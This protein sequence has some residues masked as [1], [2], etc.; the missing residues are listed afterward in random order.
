VRNGTDGG[1]G[2]KPGDQWAISLCSAH[3][4][5]QHQTGEVSFAMKHGIDLLALARE[6][7]AR[8]PHRDKLRRKA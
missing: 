2:L 8:S 6:F 3:H 5:E 4:R 1:T 7:A